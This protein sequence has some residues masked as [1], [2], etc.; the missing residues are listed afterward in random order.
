MW[1]RTK[2][3]RA[4]GSG[5]DESIINTDNIISI[6]DGS[7]DPSTPG[8]TTILVKSDIVLSCQNLFE[9][10]VGMVTK[11]EMLA[12]SIRISGQAVN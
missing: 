6:L 9:D 4:D 10:V 2:L 12:S 7:E 11:G 3:W 1:I 8:N 5:A